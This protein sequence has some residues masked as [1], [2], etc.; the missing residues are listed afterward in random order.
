M[1]Y[2]DP[3]ILQSTGKSGKIVFKVC[4]NR[5]GVISYLEINELE[6]TITDKEILRGAIRSMQKYKFEPDNSAPS[7]QCG[8]YSVIIDN[9]NGIRRG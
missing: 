6:S 4:I 9:F 7:E 1:I 3:S 2:R 8:K 5:R